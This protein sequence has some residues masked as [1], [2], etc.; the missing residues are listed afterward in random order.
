MHNSHGSF[1]FVDVLAAFATTAKSVDLQVDRVDLNRS[2]ITNF[3][4]NIDT[5]EGGVPTFVRIKR[6]DAHE[7]MHAAL[8]LQV[9]VGVLAGDEQRHRFNADFFALLNI[10]GLRFETAALDP[11]LVHS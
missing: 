11:T 8:G 6:R 4:Y 2:G 7:P 9:S 3:S 10:D 1:D 5:G